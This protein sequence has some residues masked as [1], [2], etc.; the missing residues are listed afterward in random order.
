MSYPSPL[1]DLLYNPVINY[2]LQQNQVP[3]VRK[4]TIKNNSTTAWSDIAITM[5]I[6]PDVAHTWQH[7]IDAIPAG[8]AV[9]LDTIRIHIRSQVLAALT[10]R[11]SGSL[12]LKITE[13]ENLVLEEQYPLDILAYDQWNGT[14]ALP[15]MLAAFITP[16]HPEISKVIR[17]SSAILNGW[18]DNPSF[19]EYQ[20]RNPDRVRKQMAAIYEAIAE[21]HIL[22]CSVPAS[23]EEQGQRV[24]LADTIFSQKM[25]N[26]LDMS[27]LYAACLE[28]VGIHPIVIITKGHAF[29]GA[30][31]VDESFADPVSDDASLLTK[32]MAA[33]INEI[34]LVEATCM[35]AG[36]SASFDDAVRA[37]GQHMINSADFG[38][39]VDVKR[40]RFGRIRPLPLRIA[41]ATGFEIIEDSPATQRDATAPL[42]LG[43]T[44]V[45]TDAISG[46]AG[47][48]QLWE[49]K[50]LDL[51]LRNNL[52]NLRVTKG[53]LQF[54][55]INPAK[56]EDA[57]SG[58]AEFQILPKPA[59]WDNPLRSAGLYQAV[60]ATDPM[61]ELA[62]YELTQKRLRSYLS[63]TELINNLTALYRSSRLAI[64]ENGASTL[65]IALGFLKWY[66]TA[67]SEVPRYAPILLLP[68]EI[69][70]KSARQGFIIRSREDEPTLNITLLEKLRQDYN[71]SITG[72]DTLPRDESGVDVPAIFN[73]LRRAVME[74]ARW[75]VEEQVVL[76]TFSFSKFI[77]W[78]DIHNNSHHLLQNKIVASLVSGKLEWQVVA[79]TTRD[80]DTSFSP[81]S[82]ALP[83]ATD[84]SQ[85]EAI[86][87]SGEGKSFVL[88]GP[89]GTGKSQ[90][91]TN[92]IANALYAGKKVLFVAAK[93]AALD[94]V[95]S[96][97]ENI[98]I[99]PFCLELHSNKAKKTTLIEQLKQAAEVTKKPAAPGFEAEATRLAAIRTELNGYVKA[100]HHTWPFGFSLYEAFNRYSIL[101]STPV[102]VILPQTVIAS[103]TAAQLTEWDD[104]VGELE[105][106]AAI[107]GNPAQHPLR[108]IHTTQYSPQLKS[109]I[110]S[111][112]KQYATQLLHATNA[113]KEASRL[114]CIPKTPATQKQTAALS[115][116]AKTIL[117]LPDTPASM[118]AVSTP[119]TTFTRI[120]ELAKNGRR[121]DELEAALLQNFSKG[122]LSVNAETLLNE[123]NAASHKWFLPR[124][125]GQR[126]IA[127][128]LKPFVSNGLLDKEQIAQTLQS[129]IAYQ[130]EQEILDKA[131]D[132]RVLAGNLWSSDQCDWNLLE[133]ACDALTTVFRA[134]AVLTG[135]AGLGAWRQEFAAAIGDSTGMFIAAH[136]SD[137]IE[138]GTSLE[139]VAA[140]EQTLE[141]FIGT[142]P[143]V[144]GTGKTSWM[145]AGARQAE[146]QLAGID[147]LKDWTSWN[148]AAGKA[149]R[150]GL[151]VLITAYEA[152]TLTATEI[153]NQYRQALY[154]GTAEYI[155]GQSPQLAAFN[156][157][158]FEEKIARFKTI[159]DRFE[160]LTREE[161]Y[162][163]LSA[164]I[165][166]FSIEASQSSEVGILQKAIRSNGRGM[167]IRKLFDSIPNLLP[168][169]T[170]CM[171]MSPISV[172]QYFDAATTK[173][174]L[175]IFDEASQ[176]PTCEAVGAIARGANVIVVGDPKQMPPTSFFATTNHDEE[177]M[178]E[179]LESILDDCL[180]LSMPSKHLLWHYRSKHESLIA[181][182][183]ARYY[184]NKL[185][186][187]PSTDDLAT[188]VTYVQVPGFY[189]KGKTRQNK[190]EATAIVTEI[191]RRLADPQLAQ[192]SMGV[193]T[194]SSVQQNLI[195]DLL[196]EEFRKAPHLEKVALEAV[197]PIFIKNLENVQGDERDVI[198]FSI[199]YGPDETGKISLNFGPLNREG[200]WRR[201]NVAVS[202]ARYE[203]K[204]FATLRADEI[205]L[206]RT[207]S[208]GV[209]G[210]KAFLA[211]AEK[212][213][214]ALPVKAGQPIQ[215]TA[216]L[217]TII[218]EKIR[219]KGYEVNRSIGCS[220][221]RVDIGIV[222]PER[223]SEYLLGILCD[224]NNYKASQTAR[225]RV[226]V[227]E[228]VLQTL[229]WK[230]HR[231]WSP[232]W[233]ENE[234]KVLAGILQAIEQ[235]K[236]AVASG[237]V[238]E[239]QEPL[240][241]DTR[242]VDPIALLP[243][244]SAATAIPI[245]ATAK[246]EE[247]RL[248]YEVCQL[249]D[250]IN[251]SADL[252]VQRQSNDRI[253]KQISQ[254]LDMESPISKSLLYRRVLAAWGIGRAGTRI[255]AHLD[256]MIA[257][258]TVR[259][260]RQ[261]K[262]L[263]LWKKI[264]HPNTYLLYRL[265]ADET[266]KRD[267]EDMPQEEIANGIRSILQQQ[268][269]MPKSD[270][271]RESARLF[272]YTRMGSKV[273][274]A[275]QLGIEVAI[276]RGYVT[277]NNDRIIYNEK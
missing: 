103:L 266:Q 128:A 146:R 197:E 260:S 56:L 83:I 209:A 3:V 107:V 239:K 110:A 13:R 179:D 62:Q 163:K 276:E 53:T 85:L 200:G 235:A 213:K 153:G 198:L 257:D 183:N 116:L 102:K 136:H 86:I 120:K 74:Q 193:V 89:P 38:L 160:K 6:E 175:I 40:A 148:N 274:E 130:A 224:G 250:V 11:I 147:L 79:E 115:I 277:E 275:M 92:I 251:A 81:S 47:K 61:L 248:L 145:E 22:Y 245:A 71:I 18:T 8:G 84:S 125:I 246:Q 149:Q 59:D 43:A 126:K 121:R 141:Q 173:F 225:D 154:R 169:L 104:A 269:S 54:I 229:G 34:T 222:N 221:Y 261:G 237:P 98:G 178:E 162:A 27:L 259:Q 182:S 77:L 216:G 164:R 191:L 70:R 177:N 35:N 50:L 36:K 63:E 137:L 270:L 271:L 171:L 32:R 194:F 157:A 132:T 21:L 201:L 249:D 158:V 143:P 10:E 112:L 267:A 166:D 135:A 258:M 207:A 189:D 131:T 73:I 108:G 4:L 66:E 67:A 88:H 51:T 1:S 114:L 268:L 26:C 14:G 99:G 94:V 159:S 174:D 263:F 57:L 231:V 168:R 204:V 12:V 254:V 42:A 28:A 264:Q 255:T 93:K 133:G 196:T 72:L 176:M 218:A 206:T 208:E 165:P 75:D 142:I 203:M 37:A 238:A 117:G 5:S 44:F 95:E 156:S 210:L 199:C 138:M 17:R 262:Q 155:I 272:G 151:E 20:S 244:N 195:E 78:N 31:L 123:W 167:S 212:G 2:A 232:D 58:G 101:E 190:S 152:D 113:V 188:K 24:R 252:F 234:D 68:V 109:D 127:N 97:L 180:A 39:F 144:D 233:W 230:L 15:E 29:A 118:L 215:Q 253:R 226:V 87:S 202:R 242:T 214:T 111:A 100:L 247:T 129:I 33:G 45:A 187:F 219:A 150:L 119:E 65:Y 243:L 240:L 205:D 7:R 217:E 76:G 139:K 91:I 80:L 16:N 105:I 161:L 185:L 96:R 52:L 140:I 228:G 23:F 9:E 227:Q 90:T 60:H 41:T 256:A 186:T 19:D 69:I 64:E 106:L 30:W 273:D 49:R 220:G 124:W 265:P 241:E 184:D 236:T 55:S 134:A 25:G 211:F 192:R 170:P 48:Q 223:P 46:P 172:A 181:F 82:I 122:I